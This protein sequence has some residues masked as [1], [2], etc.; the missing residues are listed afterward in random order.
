MI[1]PENPFSQEL[2]A[3]KYRADGESFDDYCV[4]YARTVEPQDERRFRHLLGALRSQRILPAGRQQLAVG[5]PFQVT[6]MNC[7]V[8][9][10]IDDSMDGIFEELRRSALTLRTGGGC[11]WDFSTLRPEGDNIRRLGFKAEASG[12]KSFMSVWDAMCGT[13]M[14]AG[15]RRGAM[16]G[17]MRVDHPDILRFVNAKQDQHTLKNFNISVAVTDEFMEA[18]ANDGLYK[19]RFG[20][21]VYDEVRAI[22]VWATMMERNW[23]WAEPGVLFIDRINQRNN[24]YYCEKIAATNPCGEQ[25]L[26][27][28]GACLL[29]SLNLVK[30]LVPTM[31][32]RRDHA[33]V[34]ERSYELDEELLIEDVH[35]SVRAFDTVID[36]THYPLEQQKREQQQKRRMGLGVTGVANALETMGLRYGASDY[37]AEQSRVLELIQVEAYRASAVL[38]TERG[39]FPL[40]DPKYLDAYYVKKLPEGLRDLIAKT[41]TRNSLLTSIAPTGTISLCADNVS[42][43]IEPVFAFELDRLVNMPEGQR[44]VKVRDY[45]LEKFGVRGRTTAEVTAEEHVDVLCAAQEF[46]D[47]AVS[48][49][50]NVYGQRPG[51]N[52]GVT[53]DDFKKLYLRAWEGGAKGCT[54]FNANGKRFG[55]LK[56][57][58]ET[59]PQLEEGAACF[60]DPATGI[61]TCDG[62]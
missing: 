57:S 11:G 52:H 9:G 25:P 21:R 14:S 26:P 36:V 17:V 12:P 38:A 4:R 33:N 13:V 8:G 35:A 2:H 40:F 3:T 49:T 24:L 53:F 39:T 42:S 45:A 28:Y 62:A 20:G 54:T 56:S 15:K 44:V 10:T 7:Y 60:V 27:P 34:F 22:D 47:S 55:I 43:G 51:S 32:P 18:L 23:D 59:E 30:Y 37:L 46:V 19:L 58:E 50:C 61:R 48:K 41:G 5:R 16:M 31:R 1:G 29:G 6:A